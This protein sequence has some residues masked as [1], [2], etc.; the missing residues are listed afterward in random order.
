MES[1]EDLDDPSWSSH[2]CMKCYPRRLFNAR[3]G[4]FYAEDRSV[5]R[6]RRWSRLN[7]WKTYIGSSAQIKGLVPA[8]LT[9]SHLIFLE[10]SYRSPE[11]SLS[12]GI[13][14]SRRQWYQQKLF[15]SHLSLRK[16]QLHLLAAQYPYISRNPLRSMI[17]GD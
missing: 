11:R 2:T 15:R 3:K 10:Q 14:L 17:S 1:V 12:F 4:K 9:R 7:S 16:H 5:A 13:N 6:R 8:F